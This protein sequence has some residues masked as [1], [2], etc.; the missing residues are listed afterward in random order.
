MAWW[1]LFAFGWCAFAAWTAVA[2]GILRFLQEG[3]LAD[4][5][6][7]LPEPED[8][9]KVSV[10]VPALDEAQKIEEALRSI[11]RMDY[12]SL[13][14]I[15]VDDRS[16]DETG[17]IMDRVAAEEPR[18]EAV[19][20]GVLPKGWLG[21]CHALHV[22]AQRATGDLLLFTDG[23][24]VFAPDTL[25]LAVRHFIGRRLDHLALM[26]GLVPG[27]YWEDAVKG[28][29]AMLFISAVKAWAAGSASKS[30]YVGIGA[31]NLVSRS[32]YERIGG[33]E[34]IRLEV[35]EDL[36]LG[37]NIKQAGYRQEALIAPD[38]VRLRWQ[39]G[40]R[41]FVLGLEKNGFAG[42]GYSLSLLFL[43]TLLVLSCY[44]APYLGVLAFRDSRIFGYA[45][46]VLLM[47]GIFGYFIS[48]FR[49]GSGL[50]ALALPVAAFIYLFS[51]WRSAAL[52]LRRRGILWRGTFYPLDVLKRGSS[53]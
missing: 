53:E 52:T 45:A 44:A 25:R 14:V 51:I 7:S 43:V 9:P 11:A 41:G 23:D 2:A 12:P 33:H 5:A 6:G 20:V 21:K 48:F 3:G 30:V 32:A 49:K 19:H 17:A 1:A 16:R 36:M 40:V 8:W 29:F 31:F 28:Y 38:H 50:V 47:H 10:V 46:A 26:P 15:A 13:E 42:I 37:K 34:K 39:E 4:R 35:A 24:V 22:G 27:G 18:V